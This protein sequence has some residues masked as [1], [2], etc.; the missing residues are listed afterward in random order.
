MKPLT[1][2]TLRPD[3]DC[4]DGGSAAHGLHGYFSLSFRVIRGR[5]AASVSSVSGRTTLETD[6]PFRDGGM[7]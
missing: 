5:V 6:A 3:T 4:T 2:S 1:A 7:Q